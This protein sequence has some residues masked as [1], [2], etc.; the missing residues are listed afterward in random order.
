VVTLLDGV[1][2]AFS[3][4]T[5]LAF[6]VGI[7]STQTITISGN[8]TPSGCAA[9]TNILNA[10]PPD[11]NGSITDISLFRVGGLPIQTLDYP[12]CK[13]PQEFTGNSLQVSYDG[14][15]KAVPGDYSLFLK[16]TNSQ[17]TVSQTYTIHLATTL[18]IVSP[19]SMNVTAGVP[20]SFTV[21][22]TGSP[23]PTLSMDSYL[24]LNG[25]NL[26]DNGDGTA[27]IS[28]VYV[29]D[30][31][32]HCTHLRPQ[33]P[34][35][36]NCGIIA[37]IYNPDNTIKQQVEQQFDINVAQPPGATIA[38]PGVTFTAGAQNQVLL[39]ATGATTPVSWCFGNGI[40]GQYP[41]PCASN[42]PLS[43]LTLQDH[44]DGTAMLS[45]T[46]PVGTNGPVTVNIV[47]SAAYT[48]AGSQPYT[49]TVTDRPLFTTPNSATF[50]A[51][52]DGSYTVSA[53]EG[54]ISLADPVPGGLQFSPGGNSATISGT[55]APGTGG[56]YSLSFTTNAGTLGTA[57]QDLLLNVNEAP[58]ITSAA[59]ANMF[60]GVP[61][62]FAV[63]TSGFP[64]VSN[65]MIP[66]NPL[67][68]TDP[69]QGDGMDFTVTGLPQ[70]LQASNLNTEGFA[71]PTL[72]IQGTPTAAGTYPVQ[73]M[74][75]N[76]VGQA[77]QQI[78][79]L[80]IV[81]ITGPAP[82]SGST[83]NGNY[84]GT[85]NGTV[86]VRAG[87]NCAFFGGGVNGNVAVN[88]GHIALSNSTVSGNMTVQGGSGF[89]F[90]P[91]TKIAGTLSIQNVG[92]G[93]TASQICQ[94]TVSGNLEISGNAIPI[95]IGNPQNSCSGSFFLKNVDISGNTGSVT[96]YDNTVV[97]NLTCS[98]NTS[99]TGGGNTAQQ[100]GGQ[101]ANF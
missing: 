69:S 13:F 83:C 74:A 49:I 60:V 40:Q 32:Q 8:P 23:K 61:G 89:S 75:Q 56:Q 12:G 30:F 25:L 95:Q 42:P 20:T 90:G 17:G 44:G 53:T 97:K 87:Q 62:I 15:L 39:S 71:G 70:G 57:S 64:S 37:T 27:T 45:G 73:I 93:S 52:S 31:S 68:P 6:A 72:T 28:G 54:T 78:L 96:F 26:H 85:F 98:A 80:N 47:S 48:L 41:L 58:R 63:T 55:P 43:W 65:H 1:Q 81:Q 21:V 10:E 94:A 7:P 51:G 16:Y 24:N 84:N 9:S 82:T 67:P 3:Q 34:S 4:P 100:K 38:T 2:P 33:G 19:G 18:A 101:C 59:T 5:N 22:A 46:P 91:G 86:T 66:A 11:P 88:G 92:S 99:I 36:T 35:G 29:S 14:N 77:A 76:G 50:T 79:T